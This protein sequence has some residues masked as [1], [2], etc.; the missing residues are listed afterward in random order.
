MS[1]TEAAGTDSSRISVTLP[2]ELVRALDKRLGKVEGSRGAVIRRLIGQE[3]QAREERDR[4]EHEERDLVEHYVRG[5]HE[6]PQTDEEFGWSD[7]VVAEA[8]ADDPWE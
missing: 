5:W 8:W 6:Q 2:S 3:L 7:R 1:T 4:R